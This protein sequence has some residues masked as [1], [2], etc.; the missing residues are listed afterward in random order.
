MLLVRVILVDV[1]C[2]E[3]RVPGLANANRW[4]FPC[5]K[6]WCNRFRCISGSPPDLNVNVAANIL[7]QCISRE[8]RSFLISATRHAHFCPT[9]VGQCWAFCHHCCIA[10]S[11]SCTCLSTA[12]WYLSAIRD[13]RLVCILM[14]WWSCLI[15]RL[16]LT[17]ASTSLWIKFKEPHHDLHLSQPFVLS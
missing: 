9:P 10:I 13:H 3:D 5:S 14:L 6:P 2:A 7:G 15:S 17:G 8:L 1:Q 4:R 12:N 11:Q 16:L